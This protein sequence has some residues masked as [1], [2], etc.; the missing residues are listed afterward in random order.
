MPMQLLAAGRR[1]ACKPAGASLLRFGQQP[2]QL[3]N[4]QVHH[5]VG[6][7]G[8]DGVELPGPARSVMIED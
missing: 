4:H 2:V 7:L 6:I 5:I 8:V 3:P 1:A